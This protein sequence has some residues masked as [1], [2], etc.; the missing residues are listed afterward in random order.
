MFKYGS[1]STAAN[2]RACQRLAVVSILL[3]ELC[4]EA[5]MNTGTQKTQ[6]H[7]VDSALLTGGKINNSI[8]PIRTTQNLH[9]KQND[10]SKST[11]LTNT[12][13]KNTHD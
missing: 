1:E 9:S 7:F 13:Y 6:V 5:C 10:H 2:L 12:M 3:Q 4:R 8:S 11:H